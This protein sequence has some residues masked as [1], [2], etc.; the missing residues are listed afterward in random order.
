MPVTSTSLRRSN[1]VLH[2]EEI[3]LQPSLSQSIINSASELTNI[4]FFSQD[5]SVINE[6]EANSAHALT[7]CSP[8]IIASTQLE[9]KTHKRRKMNQD[10]TEVEYEEGLIL[11]FRT[12]TVNKDD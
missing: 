6:C 1:V 11:I 10:F 7:L 12:G 3:D 5:D 9:I 4:S 8:S 2:V